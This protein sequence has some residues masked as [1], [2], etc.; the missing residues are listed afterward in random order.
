MK[1]LRVETATNGTPAF[2][3]QQSDSV[4][5]ADLTSKTNKTV[6]VPDKATKV[7]YQFYGG[8][9]LYVKHGGVAFTG[10]P[11]ASDI[12]QELMVSPDVRTLVSGQDEIHLISPVSGRLILSFYGG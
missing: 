12:E 10:I 11:S 7:M 3:I 8:D 4:I 9:L 1:F 6:P 5:V 2:S